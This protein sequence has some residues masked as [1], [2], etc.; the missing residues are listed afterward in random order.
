[1]RTE[2]QVLKNFEELGYDIVENNDKCLKLRYNACVIMNI[3]RVSKCY[4][5]Y[6]KENLLRSNIDMQEHKL[7]HELFT[8]WEWL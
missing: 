3:S 8:I 2:E 5:C 4:N 7:L 6:W 1:M